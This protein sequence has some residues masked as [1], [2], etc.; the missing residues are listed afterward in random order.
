MQTN[1][2]LKHFLFKYYALLAAVVFVSAVLLIYVFSRGP[3]SDFASLGAVA[4]GVVSFAFGVQNQHLAE[5]RLFRDLFKEFNEKYDGQNEKLNGIYCE[6]LPDST[7]FTSDQIDTLYNYFNL[8]GEEYLYFEK[9]FIY[10]E[11][12]QSWKNGMKYFRQNPRVKKLWDEELG[13][14]SYYG[15][16]F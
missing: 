2:R 11:V 6:K 1:H 14:G 9:G 15:L 3:V 12:W 10:P 16:E 7:P 8:C 4:V 5:V 13:T